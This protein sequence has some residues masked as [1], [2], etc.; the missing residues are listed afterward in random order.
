LHLP[1]PSSAPPWPILGQV[2]AEGR[3]HRLFLEG[4]DLQGPE[5]LPLEDLA[6]LLED[7]GGLLRAFAQ[8]QSPET[9]ATFSLVGLGKGSVA[10]DVSAPQALNLEKGLFLPLSE[11][12]YE[13]LGLEVREA[14]YGLSKR[15]MAKDWTLKA[16]LEGKTK[17]LLGAAHPVP[18]PEPELVLEDTLTLYGEVIRLGGVEPKLDL[19]TPQGEYH[20]KA[21]RE[22]LKELQGTLYQAIGVRVRGRF[23]REKGGWR[24]LGSPELLEVLPYQGAGAR[25]ALEGLASLLGEA[26]RDVDPRAFVEKLRG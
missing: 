3:V 1:S 18:K 10:L 9:P 16:H 21:S 5:D 4:E 25:E 2:E 15:L 22:R 6:G 24:P 12:R 7:L 19:R 26:Y 8:G 13:A 17:P 23:A 20:I 14:A 11:G